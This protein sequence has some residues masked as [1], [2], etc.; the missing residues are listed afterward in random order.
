MRYLRKFNENK[1]GVESDLEFIVTKIK[2]HFKKEE[3]KNKIEADD[4]FDGE[5]AVVDMI[6][7]FEDEFDKVVSDEDALIKLLEKEYDI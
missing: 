6:C 5:T 2:Q 1:E 7:W 3:I 4:E